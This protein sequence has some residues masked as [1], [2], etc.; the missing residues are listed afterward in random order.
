[1][2]WEAFC[3]ESQF[4]HLGFWE[5]TGLLQRVRGGWWWW[6]SRRR[7]RRRRAK[8]FSRGKL[9]CRKSDPQPRSGQTSATSP[10][11]FKVHHC[12]Q[13]FLQTLHPQPHSSAYGKETSLFL[14]SCIWKWSKEMLKWVL[15][16]EW[17]SGAT[18]LP[19][20]FLQLV[21]FRM[22]LLCYAVSPPPPPL[23]TP[24]ELT[25]CKQASFLLWLGSRTL[26]CV[27]CLSILFIGITAQRTI[28]SDLEVRILFKVLI[29][30]AI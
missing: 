6:R 23:P 30:I 26:C 8:M 12:L 19:K 4:H 15:P 24:Q 28:I 25:N 16:L 22:L 21:F 3:L 5:T 14:F 1:V 27:A 18:A 7:R 9:C 13:A 29:S 20:T 2:G 17:D 10:V 11:G